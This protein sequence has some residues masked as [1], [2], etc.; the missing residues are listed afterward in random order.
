[1]GAFRPSVNPGEVVDQLHG[2]PQ[3]EEITD[4]SGGNQIDSNIP[5]LTDN[6]L[7]DPISTTTGTTPTNNTSNGLY[8]FPTSDVPSLGDD[9]NTGD[10]IAH[11]P[12]V[13][14]PQSSI[15]IKSD[16]RHINPYANGING[17]NYYMISRFNPPA[18][19]PYYDSPQLSSGTTNSNVKSLQFKKPKP[20]KLQNQMSGPP[21]R[22]AFVMKLWNMVNDPSNSKYISWLPDGKAFQV[23]DRE[24]FMRHV[25]PKYF[26]HNNFASF[27]RQL[28]MYGWHKIQDVNSGS[29]VQG[30]EVWQFENPNFI[31]GK[32]NLLDNIV[33]NRSSK[34][35][36]DDI[37]INTLLME[38]ESMKQ[39]QRMIADDLSRLVQDN[40][41]LWK[42]NYMARER[43]KA[44]SETLDKILRFLVTLY[45]GSS[46]FLESAGGAPSEFLEMA[47]KRDAQEQQH[48]PHGSDFDIQQQMHQQPSSYYQP[49][50]GNSR[51]MLTHR[52]HNNG[53]K[54]TSRDTS[55][56]QSINNGSDASDL[57]IQEIRRGP[58]NQNSEQLDGYKPY[59]LQGTPQFQ[60]PLPNF[61]SPAS[62]ANSPRSYFP[63]ISP[64]VPQS[65][66]P[67]TP[68]ALSSAA[69]LQQDT[70]TH[71]PP[72]YLMGNINQQL[73][74][75]QSSIR[76]I[77]DWISRLAS[78]KLP[79]EINANQQ[80]LMDDFRMDDFL[81]PQT[82]NGGVDPSLNTDDNFGEIYNPSQ[83]ESNESYTD[84][85]SSRAS[86]FSS[87]KRRDSSPSSEDK[88][89]IKQL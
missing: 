80:P 60:H 29:L 46:K 81:L 1:M 51:L 14:S 18:S 53:S 35:E 44:Q 73:N 58:E 57:P 64:Q 88:K 78:S 6:E 9:S 17:N 77:N 16:A 55:S 12:V 11:T 68:S 8:P 74:K 70:D 76:Q 65:S 4:K 82:P 31:R 2:S 37:D 69:P 86:T 48:H 72:E 67:A 79:D 7:L 10:H 52:A 27:V 39:K 75:Q 63:E 5:N 20:K 85:S 26:K 38:L 42:E 71:M 28:N 49:Q 19:L 3:I 22:P 47:S 50:N 84:S 23:S 45:G 33:R 61:Q 15:S 66:I 30:E 83:Q 62:M 34:E 59:P 21:K 87:K 36:D 43:H 25:L 13:T 40:E 54:S 41:L 24:S 89:R 32:E 56:S